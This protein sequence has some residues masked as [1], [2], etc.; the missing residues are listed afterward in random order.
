MAK[1]LFAI[2]IALS[3]AAGFAA[4]NPK[5]QELISLFNKNGVLKTRAGIGALEAYGAFGPLQDIT[6]EYHLAKTDMPNCAIAVTIW[7]NRRGIKTPYQK[8]CFAAIYEIEKSG[9]KAIHITDLD[10]PRNKKEVLI[11]L[12][13]LPSNLDNLDNE[14]IIKSTEK[15]LLAE[16]D[17]REA[18]SQIAAQ[19]QKKRAEEKRQQRLKAA[20]PLRQEL[21]RLQQGA[22][23]KAQP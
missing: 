22:G 10:D 6:V 23:E 20:E 16:N 13:L 2:L 9:F 21:K 12:P 18:L 15:A 8:S 7:K 4:P 5:V 17:I 14:K 11:Y 1:M 3:A 19:G